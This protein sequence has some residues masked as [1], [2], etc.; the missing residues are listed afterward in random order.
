MVRSNDRLFELFD[1]MGLEEDERFFALT[2]IA[3]SRAVATEELD[4]FDGSKGRIHYCG[5]LFSFYCQL[6]Q[7]CFSPFSKKTP[8]LTVHG[9]T[10]GKD[11]VF[12]F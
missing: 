1:P 12:D 3:V 8:L 2:L 9:L 11:G 4:F 10:T 6:Q 7:K 5:E